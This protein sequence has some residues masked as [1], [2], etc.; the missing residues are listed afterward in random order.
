MKLNQLAA[1]VVVASSLPLCH[2]AIG[3]TAFS[4]P[5]A[6][7][8]SILA[9]QVATPEEGALDS[10]D[11]PAAINRNFPRIIEQNLAARRANSAKAWIDQLS[12]LELQ[13]LAQLYVD[14]NASA[15]RTGKLLQ[16]AASRLDGARLGRLSKFFGHEDV[17]AAVASIAPAKLAGFEANSSLSFAAPVV[18]AALS[19]PPTLARFG[20]GAAA[21]GG[22]TTMSG[23]FTPSVSMTLEQ[24]YAGFR[25]MQV[26]SMATTGAI[27]E[28]AAYAGRNL[29]IA[30]GLGYAFGS[31]ITYLMQEYEAAFYYGTFV[32]WVGEPVAWVN[33][34]V[35]QT[36]YF[37]SNVQGLGSY[38]SSTLPT[39]GTT[40]PQ[41][42]S[43]G[44]TGGD[45]ATEGAYETF[46]GGSGDTC[47]RGESCPPDWPY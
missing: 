34:L 45:W 20:A 32:N 12:D 36:Y 41:I 1:A 23:T 38:Q 10:A 39:M 29:V 37:G 13:H 9:D 21:V 17:R 40:S 28:T 22:A 3:Y 7:S 25:S 15:D 14:S 30:W 19:V 5:D 31:G 6:V 43:M 8:K 46:E 26:G 4:A 42:G 16:V 33:N 47:P 2:A 27:Y 44:S 35:L 11:I 24:L 18:G